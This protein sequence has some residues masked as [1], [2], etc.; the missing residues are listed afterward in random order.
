[1]ANV[2]GSSPNLQGPCRVVMIPGKG[3]GVIST[4]EIERGELVESSPL[5][6]IAKEEVPA[7]TSTILKDYVFAGSEGVA[8]VALGI[9]SLFNHDP[10][11]NLEIWLDEPALT[12]QFIAVSDIAAEQELTIAYHHL[13][14]GAT[15]VPNDVPCV[16]SEML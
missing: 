1:M 2:M 9:G 11:C 4:R 6:A 10:A 16:P 3:R 13:K 8:Y 14:P 5:I 12:M 7:A 15:F